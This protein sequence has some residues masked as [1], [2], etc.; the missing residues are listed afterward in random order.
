M[1]LFAIKKNKNMDTNDV[2]KGLTEAQAAWA[3]E[4]IEFIKALGF[5]IPY[6]LIREEALKR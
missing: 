4:K 6:G 3:L 5:A 2:L 1:A